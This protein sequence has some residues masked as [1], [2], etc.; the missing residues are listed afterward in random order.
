M[1][2][3]I[4]LLS[5]RPRGSEPLGFY[6]EGQAKLPIVRARRAA[7]L[8]AGERPAF[9]VL[10]SDSLSFSAY[11]TGRANR[12]GDFFRT[13]AGGVDLCNAPV[14]VRREPG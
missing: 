6:G 10:R 8:P 13:P 2:E 1:I 12:G 5:A 9:E 4:E 3:G 7:D 11:L 14:P